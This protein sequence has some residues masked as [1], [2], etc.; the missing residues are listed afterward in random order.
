LARYRSRVGNSDDPESASGTGFLVARMHL[1]IRAHVA[2]AALGNARLRE[3]PA[4]TLS[5]LCRVR[6]VRWEEDGRL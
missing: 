6:H 1:M 3:A 5:M 2:A 4:I